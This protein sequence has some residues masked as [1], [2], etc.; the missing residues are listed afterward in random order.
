MDTK[1]Q[2]NRRSVLATLGSGGLALTGWCFS[3]S[4]ALTSSSADEKRAVTLNQKAMELAH[5]TLRAPD[6]SG[7]IPAK[8]V[9]ELAGLERMDVDSLMLGLL[10]VARTYSHPPISNY[11]VGAVARGASGDLYLGMNVEIPGHCL[12]FSVHGEQAALSN[13]YMHGENGIAAIAVTA[14]PCGHCRQ[15]MNEMSIGGEIEILVAGQS[16]ARLSSLL[17][18]SFGPKDLGFSQG[19][20][21]PQE[22]PFKLAENSNDTLAQ[23]AL[24]S[25]RKSYAPYSESSSGV[26][27]AAKS[28]R[29]YKGSYLENA[30]FNPSL[31][32]L[33]AA[34]V[35]LLLAGDDYSSITRV[36]LTEVESAKISQASVTKTVLS[37]IAPGIE[38]QTI[39]LE[40]T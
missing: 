17:P 21:P 20:F 28:G 37:S 26:A 15:F 40:R 29:I 3:P 5:T 23:A 30:A 31:S 4:R 16:P 38:L 32:P 33:Q 35:Q 14:A 2:L 13:A 34:L 12:G 6:S 19:A 24:D 39:F 10:P 18:K 22:H 7:R 27:I 36:T 1:N 8:T 11:L 9:Q 25:A